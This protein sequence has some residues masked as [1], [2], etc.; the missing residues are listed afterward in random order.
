[1]RV[2]VEGDAAATV[3][4][5]DTH[6]N[7]GAC[8]SAYDPSGADP[9]DWVCS[10]GSRGDITVTAGG[11]GLYPQSQTAHVATS[12]GSC[13]VVQTMT[14]QL[15]GN[16]A[17][18]GGTAGWDPVMVDTCGTTDC[19]PVLTDE[20][21]VDQ[22][23][24]ALTTEGE[25][26]AW[27]P[28]S[29]LPIGEYTL[30]A[31]NMAGW[32]GWTAPHPVTDYGQAPGFDAQTLVGTLWSF[33]LP[34]T[35]SISLPGDVFGT[36]I[37]LYTM[38]VQVQIVTVADDGT[39]DVRILVDDYTTHNP[40]IFTEAVGAIDGNGLFTF[41]DDSESIT[42]SD[43]SWWPLLDV[44]DM[45]MRWGWTADSSEA[46]GVEAALTIDTR[47]L[48][49]LV[50]KDGDT[51]ADLGAACQTV[52][53]WFAATCQPC[54]SDGEPY[55]V[56]VRLYGG[57]LTPSTTDLP[58]DPATCGVDLQ[59]GQ[60]SCDF[61]GL[62]CAGVFFPVGGFAALLGRRRS[63]SSTRPKRAGAPAAP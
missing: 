30:S 18:L 49:P 24:V 1:M 57:L 53:D 25:I 54:A 41:S 35:S 9:D 12:K 55:C 3:T 60:A 56:D 42:L 31:P 7:G 27:R 16:P 50:A 10:S 48:D 51:A 28:A 59:T 23:L 36:V 58:T 62:T 17:P 14:F 46:G 61:S 21:G 15:E 52:A 29:V 2:D 45:S 47:G 38:N 34:T 8:L 26:D 40:C 19:V 39:S 37:S 5:T 11:S 6:G 43:K 63:V 33:S 13:D 32:P 22:P 4:Y 44:T 20:A